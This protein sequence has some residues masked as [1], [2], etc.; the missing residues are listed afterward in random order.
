MCRSTHQGFVDRLI[1][2]IRIKRC[3]ILL[4]P[5]FTL[6]VE[7]LQVDF[8][9]KNT[10]SVGLA[11]KIDDPTLFRRIHNL[12]TRLLPTINLCHNRND[13]SVSITNAHGCVNPHIK[14]R[15]LVTAITTYITTVS[16]STALTLVGPGPVHARTRAR[17]SDVYTLNPRQTVTTDA[18]QREPVADQL[19][20]EG[21]TV[22][23]RAAL[24]LLKL[25]PVNKQ[26]FRQL[27]ANVE[28]MAAM[29]RDL[30]PEA[31]LVSWRQALRLID[32]TVELLDQT[33]NQLEP[34]FDQDNESTL[35]QIVKAERGEKLVERLRERLVDLSTAVKGRNVTTII[36]CEKETILALAE[37]GE[38]LVSRFPY[39]V[40]SSDSFSFL[41]RLLGRARVS[42]AFRRPST[43]QLLGNIT[44]VADGFMAPVTAGN[45]V[46]L[47]I[48]DFYTGLPIKFSKKKVTPL[49]EELSDFDVANVPIFGSFDE[50]FYD[51]LTAK[52]RRIPLEII[53]NERSTGVPNLTYAKN[54][55]SGGNAAIDIVESIEN[56][57]SSRFQ[58]GL[59]ALPRTSDVLP[60]TDKDATQPRKVKDVTATLDPAVSSNPLVGFDIPGLVALNHPDRSWNGGS[61]EF[62]ALQESSIPESRRK[63]LD[64]SYAP[65]GYIIHGNDVFEQLQ[66]GDMIDS[67]FVDEWGASNLVKLR[68]SSFSEVVQSSTNDAE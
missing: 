14:R 1:R 12:S 61:S 3:S 49:D 66:P 55:V 19:L 11:A 33:R 24:C 37:V 2:A 58:S 9:R 59:S 44:I 31:G 18:L 17:M 53:R 57:I 39:D 23:L 38:L 68:Q 41:P 30:S 32:N 56:R 22:S 34:V 35:L 6:L 10:I 60:S 43:K 7:G 40:P 26:A 20:E 62:F 28:Q 13:D 4:L 47:S 65:F 50:G 16:G 64:G 67:T 5:I 29:N 36:H 21:T 51:P 48:R 52:P 63:L 45:F 8:A 42:F 27:S 46:D 15:D 54:D 25:L